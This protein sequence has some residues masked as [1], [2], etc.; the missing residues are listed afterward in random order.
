M[1]FFYNR[2]L[3]KRFSYQIKRHHIVQTM[4]FATIY[5]IYTLKWFQ[6]D[7]YLVINQ[8]AQKIPLTHIF[9]Y[10]LFF[11]LLTRYIL[12]AG[13]V[14]IDDYIHILSL[15]KKI[16]ICHSILFYTVFLFNSFLLLNIKFRFF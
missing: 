6:K 15:K 3:H 1:R 16:I 10:I 11:A 13:R 4:T 8:L 2:P 5:S 14:I 12:F 9:F 7:F